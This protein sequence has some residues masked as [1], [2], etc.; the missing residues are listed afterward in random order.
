MLV[1]TLRKSWL[2]SWWN[3]RMDYMFFGESGGHDLFHFVATPYSRAIVRGLKPRIKFQTFYH[4]SQIWGFSPFSLTLI[5]KSNKQHMKAWV[6]F[7]SVNFHDLDAYFSSRKPGYLGYHWVV[8]WK[9]VGKLISN[10]MNK[11]NTYIFLPSTLYLSFLLAN[12]KSG[13]N[14][15]KS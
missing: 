7:R 11:K 14:N 2:Y 4:V 15:L 12:F 9:L 5:N 1:L 3:F 10:Y 8:W 6:H 13:K